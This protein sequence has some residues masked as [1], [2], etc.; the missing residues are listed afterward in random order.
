MAA[1][2]GP[3]FTAGGIT[4][5]NQVLLTKDKNV[6]VFTT[7]ARIALATGI[8]ASMLVLIE[9]VAPDLAIALA[10]ATVVTTVFVRIN[11]QET[12]VERILDLTK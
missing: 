10:W 7:T 4:F 1:S 5:V 9:R 12:P 6:D 11:N 2:T 8:A 3:M